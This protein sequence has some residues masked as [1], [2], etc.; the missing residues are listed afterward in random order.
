MSS[1]ERTILQDHEQL[2]EGTSEENDVQIDISDAIEGAGYGCGTFL[3]QIGTILFC[4][5]EGAEIVILTVV[6][7]MLRCEW[8][9]SSFQLS[10]LQTSTVVAMMVAGAISSPLGD[11]VGRKPLALT[12]AIGT[13]IVGILCTFAR[14]Y[15]QFIILR[16]LIGVFIGIG[17]VPALVWSGETMPK[18]LRAMAF[19][20]SSLAWGIGS[21]IGAAIAYFVL[22]SYGWRGLI[23][24]IA[25]I[26]SPTVIFMMVINESPRYDYYQ[27]HYLKAKKTLESIYRLNGKG[28]VEIKL[29]YLESDSSESATGSRLT[30]ARV[31]NE[32]KASDNISNTFLFVLLVST[33]F[34]TYY[35]YAYATPRILNEGYCTDK[36][37]S[38]KDSC[39]FE[40][41]I[42]FDLGLINLS[43]P[44]GVLV[45][46]LLLETSLG[47]RTTL[48]GSGIIIILLVIPLYVCVGESFL[49]WFILLVRMAIASI[50]LSPTTL[51]GEYM[52]TLIR[53]F[54]MNIVGVFGRASGSLAIF[55]TEYIVNMG[56]RVVFSVIQG[57][58]IISFATLVAL[59]RE[60]RDQ[61]LL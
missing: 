58:T 7:P 59:K 8:N 29:R 43:E 18:K 61:N 22:P 49:F 20:Q 12:A 15:W 56:P 16:C 3:Y 45:T 60:T 47:R 27:G 6:G 14:A 46:L 31:Y 17:I 10:V 40:K 55:C 9:L 11:S 34:F 48:L 13:V 44:A 42:L 24:A 26:F 36:V 37:V 52:P 2:N 41:D 4:C 57:L 50:C 19:S 28:K 39:V 21:S 35:L 25:L 23:L 38:F 32:L 53:A 5:L 33:T 1:D 54:L 51:T 30:A